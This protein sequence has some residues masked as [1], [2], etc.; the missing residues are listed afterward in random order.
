ME[1]KYH[2]QVYKKTKVTESKDANLIIE[3]KI[4]NNPKDTK[5]GKEK[6]RI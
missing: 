6:G 3:K 5:D 4:V 2:P 1:Q